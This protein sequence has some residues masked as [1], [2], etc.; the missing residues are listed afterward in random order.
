LI[1]G[2][3]NIFMGDD[4][5]G[6]EVIRTLAERRLPAEVK[7]IDF[8]IRSY[9]LAFAL[10]EDY[11][12]IVLVDAVSRG[13]TPGTVFLIEPEITRLDVQP[14]SIDPHTMNALSVIQMAQ[15]LGGIKA[16]IYLVGC[17]PQKLESDDGA[18]GLSAEVQAAIPQALGMIDT[19][20]DDLLQPQQTVNGCAARA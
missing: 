17:E 20:L 11:A 15:Q 8:G 14:E 4:A 7:V 18:L 19:L 6:C 16:A 5:F 12:A 13:E 3:G 10:I 9:D 1:A 2:I